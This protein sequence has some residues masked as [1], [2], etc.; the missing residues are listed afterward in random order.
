METAR[1]VAWWIT[2]TRDNQVAVLRDRLIY[3]A[4]QDVLLAQVR[5]LLPESA[6]IP[7]DHFFIAIRSAWGESHAA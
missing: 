6:R 5:R 1:L 2:T 7:F 3:V 4:E